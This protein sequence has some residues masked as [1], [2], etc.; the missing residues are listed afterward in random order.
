[1]VTR[2]FLA[3]RGA[4]VVVADFGGGVNGV[5]ASPGP[6][7]DVAAQIKT[8]GGEAVPCSASVADEA[9]ARSIVDTATKAFGRIDAVINNAGISDPG[10]FESLSVDQFRIMMDVHFFGALFVIRAAWPHFLRAG[11]GRIVNT[12]SES[13]FRGDPRAHQL[14]VCEGRRLCADAQPGH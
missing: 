9:G 11:Y 4:H 10:P 14:R 7:A 6:A 3:S 2:S 1:M 8:D 5:G 12:V 13:M